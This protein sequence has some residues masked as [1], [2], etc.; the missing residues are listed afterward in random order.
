[1]A[2]PKQ[3]VNMNLGFATLTGDVY[4]QLQRKFASAVIEASSVSRRLN[5]VP[6]AMVC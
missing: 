3:L 5:Q 4:T 1:M 6:C 2:L